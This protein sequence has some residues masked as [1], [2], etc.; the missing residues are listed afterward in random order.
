[1]RLLLR[2]GCEFE[3]GYKIE[4]CCEIEGERLGFTRHSGSRKRS[5]KETLMKLILH[6]GNEG[7]PKELADR[8]YESVTVVGERENEDGDHDGTMSNYNN[9]E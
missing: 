6:Q 5:R 2:T 4:F 8:D 1:M 9:G 7:F 3:V